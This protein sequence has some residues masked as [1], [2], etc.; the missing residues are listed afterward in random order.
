MKEQFLQTLLS[1]A[2]LSAVTVADLQ[3]AGKE[4][5]FPKNTTI[6]REG[7]LSS[8]MY[9][10]AKGAA[11]AFYYQNDK[12]YTDWFMFE[13]MFMCSLTSFFSGVPSVQYIETLEDSHMLILT[14]QELR[15]LCDKHHDMEKLNGLILAAGLV[16]LQQNFID[17]R[18]KTAQERYRILI[19]TFPEIVKRVPL[20]HI[21]SYL[22]V[23]QETLSR[24]RAN[25]II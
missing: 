8:N 9:F 7:E 14:R 13:N 17:Q 3:Q 22:G 16:S 18:F 11:R 24:I 21:A 12:E 2:P 6:V 20:R 23:T 5:N 15:D 4:V 19:H 10:I 1:I 25:Y